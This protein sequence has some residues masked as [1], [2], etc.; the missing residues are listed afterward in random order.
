MGALGA[1]GDSPRF[2][3]VVVGSGFG[4]AVFAARLAAQLGP[5]RLA[6]LERGVEVRPGEFPE[7]LAEAAEQVRTP[8]APLGIFDFRFQRDLDALV[9]NLLGGGSELYAG[10]TLE[11]LPQTFDIR[12][13]PA[14]PASPRA[15]PR[16]IDAETLR[17]Y[18]NRVRETLEVERWVDG[19]PVGSAAVRFDPEVA[20]SWF[21]GCED[22]VDRHSGEPLRDHAGREVRQRPPLRRAAAF[23]R[24]AAGIGAPARVVPLAINLTRH[25]DTDN[26]FG[27]P[28]SA[29]TGCGNCVTGCNVGAK[30]SLTSNYLPVAASA[31]ADIHTGVE[32][33]YVRPSERPGHRWALLTRVHAPDDRVRLV[34]VHTKVV[35]LSAGV[36]GTAG[37][38]F[39]SR[40][41]GLPVPPLLGTRVSGNGDAIA[42][43]R[44]W[45]PAF[46]RDLPSRLLDEPGP[47]ITRMADLRD[48]AGRR[49]LVQDAVA[50]DAMAGLLARIVGAGSPPDESL[51]MLAM[52][53]DLSLDSRLVA[54]DGHVDVRWPAAGRDPAQLAGRATMAAMAAAAGSPLVVNPRLGDAHGGT[55]ITVHPLGG[56]PM[57][58]GV[59]DGVV[60]DVGR[61]FHPGGGVLPGCYV[62]DASVVPTAV[63]ANPSLTIAALAERAVEVVIAEDLPRLLD[64]AAGVRHATA[65]VD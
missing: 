21:W 20:G 52:G 1:D 14:D 22:G 55:P 39:G 32:V 16:G 64:G 31:G 28:R 65:E 37:I 59:E 12:R 34:V 33:L 40:Q 3:C 54:R 13:N 9:A 44:R 24:A 62:A 6:V 26:S 42:L 36:F 23:D 61:L 35:V 8:A 51:I 45:A 41:R 5:G 49:H 46:G 25:H 11:P 48:R 57:G 4:G 50:P 58:S 10:V 29:C 47:T 7:T 43:A 2:D 27:T 17:P 30:N 18:F 38:L 63:G 60:D 19:G 56:A 53:Y 15:W